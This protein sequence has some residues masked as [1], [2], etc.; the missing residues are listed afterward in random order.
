MTRADDK[1][2][3]TEADLEPLLQ[4]TA[5]RALDT[6]LRGARGLAILGD[7]RAFGLLLQL[8]READP[9]AR[10]EVCRALAALDDPRAADRLRSLLFD[11]EAAVRDAAYSA[12]A[13][14]HAAQPL[15]AAEAGLNAPFEDVRRRGLQALVDFLRQNRSAAESAG[16][17]LDLLGRA[18]NDNFAGVRG[19]AFKAALN[20]QASGGGVRTLRFLLQSIHADI[21][22][23]VLTEV[24]AQVQENWAWDLLLEFYND[25]DPKL[26]EEAFAFAVRKNKELLPLEGALRSQYADLR[27][28]A[29][30]AL[31]KKRTAAA[32]PL[33]VLALADAD[34][35]VRQRAMGAL[36]GEDAIG[37][38]TEALASPHADVRVQAARALARHGAAVALEPLLALPTA[39]EP[40]ERE[41]RADWL[42]LAESAL[43]GLAELGAPGALAPLVP[44]LQSSQA[45]LRKLAARAQAWAAL[46]HQLE[47]LRQALQHADPQVKYHAALGLAYAG[48]PLVA[49]LVCSSAAAEVLTPAERL[50]A[51]FT[52]GSAGEDQLAAFLDAAEPTRNQ[53]L[54]LMLLRELADWQ[55]AP[56]RCLACLSARPP[57]V[58]LSAARALE[59]FGQPA[60][61]R[62][63][64]VQLVNDRDDEAPWK[65]PSETVADVAELLV[66][67]SPQARARTAYLLA[68]LA[69]KEPAAWEEAWALHAERF[70]AEIQALRQAAAE[71]MPPSPRYSPEQLQ[72]LALGAYIGLV[73]EQGGSAGQEGRGTEAQVVRVRQ[74]ALARLQELALSG[75]RQAAVRPVLVQALGDPHQAVRLLAFDQLVALGMTPDELGAA[76]L[77][78]GHTDVGVRGLEVMAGGGTSA[79]GQ[80][81]LE[82]ALRSRNDDLAVEAAKLLGQRRGIVAVASLALTATYEP[83]RTQA[84]AW[85]AGE[86]DRDP[87]AQA[88]LRQ[89]LQLRHHKVVEAAARAL[90]V[91]K[92]PAA[93]DALVRLLHAARDEGPQRRLIEAIEDIGDPRTPEALLDRIQND[94]EGTALLNELFEAAGRFRQPQNAD[95]LLAMAE[96]EKWGKALAAAHVVSGFDQPI[97][98][99]EDENPDRRWEQKQFPRHDDILARLLRRAMDL[100]ANR[101]LAE[102]LPGARWARGR[103]VDPVLAVL[104]VYADDGIRLQAVEAVGFRLRNRGGPAE[105]LVK[106]LKHRDPLTQ[107]LA[108]EGLARGGYTEGLGNLLA[109]VDLQSDPALR[110]RAV[111][112]LGELGDP[113]ALD[114]LLKIVNDPESPLREAAAEALGHMG[115]SEKAEEVLHLLEALAR[116]HDDVAQSALKGLRWFDHPEGWQL[117][118]RRAAEVGSLGYTAVEL[119]GH[120]DDP[121]TRDLLLRLL[122]ETADNETFEAAEAAARRLWGLES[123][124]PDYAAVQSSMA[125]EVEDKLYRRL[126]EHG[127]ARRLLEILP[128]LGGEA[129]RRIEEILLSRQPPPLAE[130]QVVVAGPDATAAGVAAHLLGRAGKGAAPSGRAVEA[131]LRRWWEQWDRQRREAVRRGAEPGRDTG[132]LRAALASLIWAAG[133]LDVGQ[134]TLLVVAAT[135]ADVPFDRDLRRQAAAALA[136]CQPSAAV[137][138]ALEGL[139]SNDHPD[140]RA[141][142]AEAVARSAPARA[143]DVA[144]RVLSDRVAFNRL[145]ARAPLT[146]TLRGAAV[147]V[148]YQGVAV[149]HLAAHNDVTGLAA[150][151]GNRG[152]S[153][154]A[155]LGAIEG[156]AAAASEAAEAELVKIGQSDAEPEE[157]RKAAWRG[158][159]RSRRARHKR[160]DGGRASSS[161]VPSGDSSGA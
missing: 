142:A 40:A 38:L 69:E 47:T 68:H 79:Q 133:R 88:Q 104:T 55:E 42:A 3:L 127:D 157:L 37:P 10:A 63:F 138:A 126:Q 50:V 81:V 70:A 45:S 78:A 94:A 20:L 6:C 73:R 87:S 9:A 100:K 84:V 32:Q 146:D 23:E 58:R 149:P 82:A 113:R 141:L 11:S 28:Q 99:P 150:I 155:Q 103:E 83:L 65:I 77:G 96:N 43:E 115:R 114:L 108:A 152:F 8:S 7:T 122:A 24:M 21:R 136:S 72:D 89:A 106:A 36:V 102:H 132:R 74:T 98:D 86:Y 121:A 135:R 131:A 35:D 123:L 101:A 62:E 46:P 4:A 61:F 160:A 145:A 67:G 14:L 49:S 25:P 33:L 75:N 139:I 48:D 144:G 151:A 41:R 117:I 97:E 124:E 129:A 34:K 71:R 91:K 17:A 140:I 107:L 12:L 44:L 154:E 26:R 51:A 85:L 5:S 39:P 125:S 18:L 120:H 130:A 60:A 134:D 80:A 118:C 90:A 16:P 52:L 1:P 93:F 128:R 15:Q 57:R 153:E 19:E 64:V 111:K 54:L 112:A 31:I 30:D 92:D 137:L 147:Q 59:R 161:P 66:H 143:A 105:P 53:A 109:A 2:D 119:L 27:R 156:L 22:R 148:H 76:A 110:R 159:R 29:V 56:V 13:R 95:R 116:G 158:L